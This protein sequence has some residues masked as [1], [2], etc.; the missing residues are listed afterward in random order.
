MTRGAPARGNPVAALFDKAL[1][2]HRHGKLAE[3]ERLL[4]QLLAREPGHAGALYHLGLARAG[5]GEL[6]DALAVLEQA[7]AR[8]PGS[9]EAHNARGTVL[10]RLHRLDDAVASYQAALAIRPDDVDANANL[11]AALAQLGREEAALERYERALARAPT[12]GGALTNR[13]NA[14]KALGR[15]DEAC[16]SYERALAANPRD[17]AAFFALVEVRR[18]SADDPVLRAM[19]ARATRDTAMPASERIHLHFALAK[20]YADHGAHDQAFA[21][22]AAGNAL[23]RAAITYDEAGTLAWLEA[24]RASFSPAVMRAHDGAGDPAAHPVFIVG[25]PRSGTTLVEQIVAS[26]PAAFGAG[27]LEL[28]STAIADTIAAPYPQLAGAL[29]GGALARLGARYAEATRQLAPD[30]ARITDKLPLNFVYLGLIH[31][32]LPNARLIHVRRDPLDTCW[33]CFARLFTR[34]NQFTYELGELGRFYRAYE[35]LMAHWHSVIP[36]SALLEVRYEAVTGDLDAEARRIVRH[37]GLD[38][39]AACL[40]FHRTDRA[41]RTASAVQVRQPIYGEA[42]G[43]AAPYRGYLDALV[44]ALGPAA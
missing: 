39:D 40:A 32:A 41:V 28:F 23:K 1:V 10:Q 25:M 31:L 20:A 29:D 22:V 8:N 44:E 17:T 26:H 4:R 19:A 18:F 11:G 2:L 37:C 21:H 6:A 7:C 33:S 24:I 38:W 30:A 34:S 35:R 13:G 43:R 15:I 5:Q 12:H 9:A 36:P 27:E 3:A 14:L 42:V 16:A